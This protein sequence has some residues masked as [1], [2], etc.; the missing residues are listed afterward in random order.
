MR[1]RGFSRNAR[2]QLGEIAG[3]FG[4]RDQAAL[5]LRRLGLVERRLIAVQCQAQH[6][7]DVRQE[8]PR[9]AQALAVGPVEEARIGGTAQF[10]AGTA[11]NT[12]ASYGRTGLVDIVR[13]GGT[14]AGAEAGWSPFPSTLAAV[15]RA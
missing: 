13:I 1:G 2:A 11:N 12:T 15:G 4:D 6:A 10:L 7:L 3:A 9:R 14:R 5:A 8:S